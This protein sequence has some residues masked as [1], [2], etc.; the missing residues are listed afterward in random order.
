M[1]MEVVYK[2]IDVQS[3]KYFYV[4]YIYVKVHINDHS[5]Y[6]GI[7]IHIIKEF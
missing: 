6:S 1:S 5:D 3:G 4:Q 2:H 7:T